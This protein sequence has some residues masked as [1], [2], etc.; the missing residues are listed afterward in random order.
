MNPNLNPPL[1]KVL[2]DSWIA[3][4]AIAVLLFWAMG[5]GFRAIWIPV[6]QLT[7][8]LFEAV[9]ILDIPSHSFNELDR[10]Q[11][12]TSF[13]YLLTF[14]SA[15]AGA[16]ALSYWMYGTGPIRRLR[17]MHDRMRRSGHA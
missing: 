11:A 10:S 6:S 9:A 8:F 1:R 2:A 13:I 12:V 5:A 15:V 7:Y 14:A 4:V 16:S 3:D 17:N